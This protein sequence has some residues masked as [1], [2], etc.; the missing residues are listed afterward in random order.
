MLSEALN[1]T[2]SLSRPKEDE[3]I[4]KL[5]AYQRA[6]ISIK[7]EL[8]Q[9][10]NINPLIEIAHLKEN[11][12]VIGKHA[13]GD[14]GRYLYYNDLTTKVAFREKISR[15]FG[16]SGRDHWGRVKSEIRIRLLPRANELLQLS[17]VKR[18]LADA[19]AKGHKV[20]MAGGYVF[21][22]EET[23]DV[24]WIVKATNSSDSLKSGESI[25]HEGTIISKNHGRIVVFPYIKVNGEK[26]QGHTKNAPHDGK[27]K[28][29][30][31]SE[32]VELPFLVLEDDL[33]VGLFGELKYE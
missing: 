16:F 13:N 12:M 9:E 2:S 10:I 21:W 3:V 27:A 22:Y 30:H 7:D 29:R 4:L 18:M 23:G 31:P 24:G 19:H 32:Y 8:L 15:A 6:S 25:W 26:V 17:S 5:N 28:P 14:W 11:R 1:I 33:M 20:L